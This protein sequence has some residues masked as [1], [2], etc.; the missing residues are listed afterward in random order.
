MKEFPCTD[1]KSDVRLDLQLKDAAK[2]CIWLMFKSQTLAH[3]LTTLYQGI[4]V[5]SMKMSTD[6]LSIVENKI[7]ILI[8]EDK[9]T[10]RTGWLSV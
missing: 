7:K 9:S 8:N 1:N 2:E 10:S 6:I 4:R 3:T 5:I